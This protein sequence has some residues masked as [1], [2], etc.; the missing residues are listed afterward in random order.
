MV[1]QHLWSWCQFQRERMET[2][3][4]S[5]GA[6]RTL[7]DR[8]LR[9]I[10]SLVLPV[11]FP[12]CFHR[13]WGGGDG[14]CLLW[15]TLTAKASGWDTLE[16]STLFQLLLGVKNYWGAFGVS[17]TTLAMFSFERWVRCESQCSH[18]V[19]PGLYKVGSCKVRREPGEETRLIQA[20]SR[21]HEEST[22]LQPPKLI[23][24]VR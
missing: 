12:C 1:S 21:A 14:S 18:A 9:H 10:E 8:R 3:S 7:W 19:K 5:S 17:V 2:P 15:S 4:R 22:L 23:G 24:R 13:G 6:G 20:K 16:Q 11:R